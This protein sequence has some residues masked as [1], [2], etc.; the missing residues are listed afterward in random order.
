MKVNNLVARLLYVAVNFTIK[1][2]YFLEPMRKIE[3]MLEEEA[4]AIEKMKKRLL[5]LDSKF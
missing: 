3:E 4:F 1:N 5:N 2:K